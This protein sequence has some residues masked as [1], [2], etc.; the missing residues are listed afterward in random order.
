MKKN[1]T[2][3]TE[4]EGTAGTEAEGSHTLKESNYCCVWSLL[5]CFSLEQNSSIGSIISRTSYSIAE[6]SSETKLDCI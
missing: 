4:A 6:A 1:L 2:A 3:G 5:D